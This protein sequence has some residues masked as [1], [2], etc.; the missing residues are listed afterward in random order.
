MEPEEFIEKAVILLTVVAAVMYVH[1]N[2]SELA[3]EKVIDLTENASMGFR[4][5]DDIRKAQVYFEGDDGTLECKLSAGETVWRCSDEDWNYV[6][7]SPQKLGGKLRK[8]TWAHPV[9]NK[10]LIIRF[11]DE[12]LNSALKGYYGII[13]GISVDKPGI[14]TLAVLVDG[15]KVFD[16]FTYTPGLK[17]IDIGPTQGSRIEFRV[18]TDRGLRRH[19][20]FDVWS[21]SA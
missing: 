5:S 21:E 3:A 9:T 10:T 17:S 6:G 19:F 15:V 20:C 7:S 12:N 8:C 14:V 2:L 13:D 16:G 4:V 1:Y 18:F 11:E